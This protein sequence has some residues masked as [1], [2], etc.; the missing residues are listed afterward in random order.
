[1]GKV[2]L[3]LEVVQKLIV[4]A[5]D[6]RSLADS[7]QAVCTV[8]TDSLL[9]EAKEAP[10][11]PEKK[12][13]EISLEKVRGVLADKSRAGHIAEVRAIIQKF[14]A[15]RLSDID[16][17]E[18]TAI[19]KEAE[20]LKWVNIP[21]PLLLERVAGL[22]AHRQPDWSRNLKTLSLRHPESAVWKGQINNEDFSGYQ[23]FD[24]SYPF[25]IHKSGT[26]EEKE[27]GYVSTYR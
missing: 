16:P 25:S 27:S 22:T 12:E 19:I 11:L 17:K 5:E 24:F 13:P 4:V 1:M 18:Y 7:V 10:K 6:I 23:Y 20:V 14:G 2:K 26:D 8:I 3:L 21:S 9:V 15:D